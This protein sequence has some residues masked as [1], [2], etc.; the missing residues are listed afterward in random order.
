MELHQLRC[1][2]A[3][4][5]TLH[6]GHAAQ[7]LDMLPSALGRQIKLL[8][9]E[10]GTRLFTRSTRRVA[11]T[12]NGIL[13]RGEARKLLAHA[14]A[15]MLQFRQNSPRASG[16]LRVGAID[17]AAIGLVPLLLQHFRRQYPHI[18]VQ[19]YEDKTVSLLPKLKSGRLDI[20][21]VRPP[22]HSDEAFAQRFLCYEAAIV[23]LPA[24]HPLAT[25][26]AIRIEEL[27][28]EPMIVPERR[29]RPHSYDLTMNLFQDV[30]LQ[31]KIT[32]VADEKQTII[33]LVAAGLGLAIVPQ[34]IRRF[35]VSGVTFVALIANQRPGLPLAAMWVKETQDE[36][37]AAM[38]RVLASHPELYA[39]TGDGV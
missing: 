34:W 8:E 33:H 25:R 24:N 6:F 35:S 18:E 11:L 10:L 17:S 13:L 39:E 37:R 38:L 32:Q 30:G 9:E 3:V 16:L 2:L 7:Q 4:T 15:I 27:A 31:P 14:D 36:V 20:A 26:E 21:F 29:S 5:E 23:A 19:I 22:V 28:D 12:D 1:F